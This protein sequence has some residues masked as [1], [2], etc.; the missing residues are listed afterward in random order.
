MIVFRQNAP[1]FTITPDLYKY[2]PKL[3]LDL[4]DALGIDLATKLIINMGGVKI[5]VPATKKPYKNAVCFHMLKDVLGEDGLFKLIDIFGG[6]DLEIPLCTKL[7][8]FVLREQM[9]K[10]FDSISKSA[11]AREARA[12]ICIKYRICDRSVR[13]ILNG[14]YLS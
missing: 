5:D 14:E 13:R 11:S 7:H 9:I 2:L 8:N 10:E 12:A 4:I 1:D 6:N 3:A